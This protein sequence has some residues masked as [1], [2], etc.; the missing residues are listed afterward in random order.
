MDEKSRYPYWQISTKKLVTLRLFI[1]E[2]ISRLSSLGFPG[3]NFIPHGFYFNQNCQR[4]QYENNANLRKTSHTFHIISCYT[5]ITDRNEG[6]YYEEGE[7]VS[8][9]TD[10]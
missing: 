8:E 10:T 3:E 5:D 4:S 2:V 7:K 6:G 1:V 9:S